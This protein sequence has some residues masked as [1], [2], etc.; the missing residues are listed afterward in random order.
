MSP[1]SIDNNKWLPSKSPPFLHGHWAGR[2]LM[3]SWEADE[4]C[5]E[6][7]GCIWP[8][9]PLAPSTLEK[10]VL[11]RRRSCPRARPTPLHKYTHTGTYHGYH[12]HTHLHL[13][14]YCAGT[15]LPILQER[16]GHRS[17][18][19]ARLTFFSKMSP[20]RREEGS[21]W[22]TYVCLWRIHFDIWQN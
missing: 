6:W 12:I 1:W 4:I 2:V 19:H 10:R 22:G 8:F 20:G 3:A 9:L 16:E 11:R 17:K 13:Y 14:T 21:G 5:P 18:S 7:Q 15:L